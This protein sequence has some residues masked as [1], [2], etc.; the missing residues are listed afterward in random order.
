[1]KER[2]F[3]IGGPQEIPETFGYSILTTGL[4]Q[5]V[6]TAGPLQR[7]SWLFTDYPIVVIQGV[8]FYLPW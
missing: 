7:I 2:P 3:G 1:M 5:H 8:E 4:F 6:F